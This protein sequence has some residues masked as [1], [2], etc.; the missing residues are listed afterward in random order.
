MGLWRVLV[1]GWAVC[2]FIVALMDGP[3]K[4]QARA[5]KNLH[6]PA[7]ITAHSS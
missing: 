1:L 7:N 3:P 6:P 2:F 5:I 4:K